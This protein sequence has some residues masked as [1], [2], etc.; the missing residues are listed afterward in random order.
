MSTSRA[1]TIPRRS[2]ASETPFAKSL[3]SKVRIGG[4]GI[5]CLNGLLTIFV[6]Q[7][8]KECSYC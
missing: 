5:L 8:R 4:Q 2:A 6:Y 7:Y 1:R 3:Q